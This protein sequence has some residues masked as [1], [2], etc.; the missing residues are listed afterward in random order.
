VSTLPRPKVTVFFAAIDGN[1]VAVEDLHAV[2]LQPIVA[3]RD[4]GHRAV[5]A[6]H[7]VGNRAGHELDTA[8]D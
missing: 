4:V 3:A 6:Q 2:F 1:R 8:I 5:A 7:Q